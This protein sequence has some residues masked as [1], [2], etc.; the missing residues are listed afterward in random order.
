MVEEGWMIGEIKAPDG[1]V[2]L[3]ELP[4]IRYTDYDK[5][6]RFV[7]YKLSGSR[8]MA[9]MVNK[10]GVLKV[11]AD[12]EVVFVIMSIEDYYKR[13][14]LPEMKGREHRRIDGKMW[15]SWR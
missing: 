11:T 14:K 8:R 10:E 13:E 12:G 2:L 3:G 15:Y 7:D 6:V 4:S 1:G 9:E 5:R